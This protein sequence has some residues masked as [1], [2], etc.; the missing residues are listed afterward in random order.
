MF[1]NK[2]KQI[3]LG[4]AT[5]LICLQLTFYGVL[6]EQLVTP[7]MAQTTTKALEKTTMPELVVERVDSP[8]DLKMVWLITVYYKNELFKTMQEQYY[9]LAAQKYSKLINMRL[10]FRNEFVAGK[11]NYWLNLIIN[12]VIKL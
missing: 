11:V 10:R 2:Y 1:F 7:Q 5:L 12:S 8:P 3:V 6:R 4:L 9:N